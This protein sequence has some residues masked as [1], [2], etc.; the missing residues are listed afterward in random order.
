[1]EKI[2][3]E[4]GKMTTLTMAM[5]STSGPPEKII[6]ENGKTANHMLDRAPASM[7]AGQSTILKNGKMT[8]STDKAPS[9]MLT[10]TSILEN[11]NMTIHTDRTLKRRPMETCIPDNGK[12]ATD[13]DMAQKRSPREE[14]IQENGKTAIVTVRAPSR[15][16]MEKSILEGGKMTILTDRTSSSTRENGNV[17]NC[18]TMF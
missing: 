14:S 4:S 3:P 6:G 5:V 2:I 7:P 8:M 10:A 1:M 12:V 18:T 11:G 9:R 15:M 16:L 13:T 17:A